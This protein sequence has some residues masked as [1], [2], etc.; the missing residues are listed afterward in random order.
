M[1]LSFLAPKLTV[2][3]QI[4]TFEVC[5]LS[6]PTLYTPDMTHTTHGIIRSTPN[7]AWKQANLGDIDNQRMAVVNSA[8]VIFGAK[9]AVTDQNLNVYKLADSQNPFFALP[10]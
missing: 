9:L 6:Q 8:T 2:K 3:C 4:L 10:I 7:E 5:Q 1:K